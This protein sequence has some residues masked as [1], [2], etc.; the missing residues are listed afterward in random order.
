VGVGNDGCR[1]EG[2]GDELAVHE[3]EAE[4]LDGHH[5]VGCHTVRSSVETRSGFDHYPRSESVR[6]R[7]EKI[8]HPLLL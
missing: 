6:F 3:G 4:A 8:A 2:G 7:G 1:L 5:H